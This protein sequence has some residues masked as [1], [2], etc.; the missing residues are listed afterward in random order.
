VRSIWRRRLVSRRLRNTMMEDSS[1]QSLV[2]PLPNPALALRRQ[3]LV[4]GLFS[5]V[6]EI[7]EVENGYAFK[8]RRSEALARRIADYLLF[9]AVNSPQLSLVLVVEPNG[10]GLWLRVCGPGE[11]KAAIKTRLIPRVTP[12][13]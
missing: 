10:G 8:F 2:S 1:D 4:T 12:A 3:M 6:S 5:S 9:E 11:S 13:L 7:E